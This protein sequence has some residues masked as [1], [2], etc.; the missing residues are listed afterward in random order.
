MD[1]LKCLVFS[2]YREESSLKGLLEP[3]R[4]CKMTRNGGAIYV[5]CLDAGH[6][7]QITEL[8][9]Y[10]NSPLALLRLGRKLVLMSPG[11]TEKE[12]PIEFPQN[13]D[14]SF[15]GSDGSRLK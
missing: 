10:L 5:E 1:R 14:A 3:L 4:F 8:V 9:V 11:S 6:L 15:L 13:I 12:Y 2:F 7:D